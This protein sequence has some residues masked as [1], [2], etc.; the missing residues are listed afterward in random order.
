[1]GSKLPFGPSWKLVNL[2]MKRLTLELPFRH[3]KRIM[4]FLH[5]P[6]DRYTL[7]AV[8]KLVVLL[9]GREIPAQATMAFITNARDY[10]SIQESIRDL[11]KRANVPAIAVDYV[12]W[13]GH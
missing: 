11:A 4:N 6:L 10:A 12:V 5:V 1:M 8:R 9:H 2:V 3:R 7:A 13:N